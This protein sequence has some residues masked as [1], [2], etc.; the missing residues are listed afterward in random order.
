MIQ[1][2]RRI[3]FAAAAVAALSAGS[4]IAEAARGPVSHPHIVAHFNCPHCWPRIRC[5]KNSRES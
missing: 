4:G 1:R 5:V 2:W 3:V